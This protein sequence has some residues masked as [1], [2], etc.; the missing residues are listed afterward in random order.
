[1]NRQYK[2]LALLAAATVAACG[3]P[4][5][6]PLGPQGLTALQ[7][8]SIA[9]ANT[10]TKPDFVAFTPGKAALGLLGDAAMRREG[11][12]IVADNGIVDPAETIARD[13]AQA[14][15]VSAGT[16]LAATSTPI[17]SDDGSPSALSPKAAGASLVLYVQ[18]RDW[19][20]WYYTAN[21]NRYR[22]RVLVSA[23]LIDTAT[24]TVVAKAKCDED[25]PKAADASPTYDEMLGAGAQRL[26]QELAKA[27]VACVATL[28]RG[29]LGS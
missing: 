10:A 9:V 18:T 15:N 11:N 28:K 20:T 25:S 7:G 8:K 14:L 3:T 17:A 22:A 2:L 12:R 16:K 1:M 4:A 23:D 6:R 21:F 29:L 19:R 26:K 13:L 27:Q 5:P 24:Q